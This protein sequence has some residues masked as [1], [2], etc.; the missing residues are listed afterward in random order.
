MI[1]QRYHGLFF[2]PRIFLA[3]NKAEENI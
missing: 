3:M 2:V 1:N